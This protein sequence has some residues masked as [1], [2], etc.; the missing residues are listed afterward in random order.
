MLRVTFVAFFKRSICKKPIKIRWEIK[1]IQKL[2]HGHFWTPYISSLFIGPKN[3]FKCKII[4]LTNVTN[5][6]QVVQ[7]IITLFIPFKC[8]LSSDLS[9]Y[10][11]EIQ[12]AVMSVSTGQILD[13]YIYCVIYIQR[14]K[15]LVNFWTTGPWNLKSD[16][17]GL[18]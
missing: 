6:G 17:K 16:E 11:M 3:I 8:L 1:R 2:G 5:R 13:C 7:K 14:C 18:F 10:L 12:G 9:L 4:L 15:T